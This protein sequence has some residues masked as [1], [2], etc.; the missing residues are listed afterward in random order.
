[1]C[2][3]QN[4]AGDTSALG[5]VLHG[6]C[7]SQT[8][9]TSG[10]DLYSLLRQAAQLPL[11]DLWN[12]GVQGPKPSAVVWG[13]MRRSHQALCT[14]QATRRLLLLL[15]WSLVTPPQPSP[16]HSAL[17]SLA[18]PSCPDC[19]PQTD[20]AACL[21]ITDI[22]VTVPSPFLFPARDWVLIKSPRQLSKWLSVECH[23]S[24]KVPFSS[25]GGKASAPTSG[26]Y[27]DS[28]LR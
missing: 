16:H 1:M 5:T 23:L 9:F 6:L 21:Q 10:C 25:G 4:S 20:R 24:N 13:W 3:V 22:L 15:P 7:G 12:G 19:G 8:R 14:P 18:Q 17:W 2:P 11:P 26:F 28:R 27:S